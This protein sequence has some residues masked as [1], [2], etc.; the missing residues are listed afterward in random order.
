M[1]RDKGMGKGERGRWV[2]WREGRKEKEEGGM[3]KEECE[4]EWW[5]GMEEK[6]KEEGWKTKVRRMAR[7]KERERRRRNGERRRWGE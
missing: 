6:G 5:E 2:E 3:E 7:G 1:A 4:G